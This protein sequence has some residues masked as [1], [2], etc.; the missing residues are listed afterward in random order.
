MVETH[1]PEL[2]GE[3]IRYAD[4][5]WELTGDVDV[6]GTGEVLAVAATQVDDVR[7]GGATLRFGLESPPAS[8]NPGALAGAF[9]RLERDGERYRLVV[10]DDRR[11]YRYV[12][13]GMQRR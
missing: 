8:L 11:T 5:T 9:D 3:T 7:H 13:H 2:R 12:L 10:G 6:R 4:H 1:W